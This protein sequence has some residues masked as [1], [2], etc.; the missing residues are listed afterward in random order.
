MNHISPNICLPWTFKVTLSFNFKNGGMSFDP[1]YTNPYQQ[2]RYVQHTDLSNQNIMI[3][4]SIYS[5]SRHPSKFSHSKRKP[6]IICKITS[7][8]P[9]QICN[10][11]F[12]YIT[13]IICQNHYLHESWQHIWPSCWCFIFH[14]SSTWRTWT[15][16]SRPC[17]FFSPWIRVNPPRI[18][19]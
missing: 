14:E 18:P 15:Q 2:T 9:F 12:L 3:Y 4:I 8:S 10:Y 17:G 5:P 1:P 19:P 11:S 7:S 16:I 6:S 13:K